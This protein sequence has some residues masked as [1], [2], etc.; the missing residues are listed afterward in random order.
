MTTHEAIKRV[1]A[2]YERVRA[3]HGPFHSQHEGY[4]VILEEV[5]ELWE[6]IREALPLGLVT[7]EAIHVGAMSLRFLIDLCPD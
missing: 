1:I 7:Q 2:E 6:S 3:L 4:A 5:D